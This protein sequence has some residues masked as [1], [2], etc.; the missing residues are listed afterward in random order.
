MTPTLIC[1]AT[2]NHC[3]TTTSFAYIHVIPLEE[4]RPSGYAQ[5]TQGCL[6]PTKVACS[7]PRHFDD[8][9][10]ASGGTN[11]LAGLFRPVF[12]DNYTIVITP[13]CRQT[14]IDLRVL[15]GI[16][17]WRSGGKDGGRED[18]SFSGQ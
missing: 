3:S 18:D 1:P 5:L 8:E 4:L 16:E 9:D 15:V 12:E 7:L 13:A 2:L 6:L 14:P 11:K 10:C 17:I